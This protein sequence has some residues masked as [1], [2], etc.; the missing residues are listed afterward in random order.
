MGAGS[1][2]NGAK[3]H[4]LWM[5]GRTKR[6]TMRVAWSIDWDS[7]SRGGMWDMLAVSRVLA[8]HKIQSIT[9]ELETVVA[10]GIAKSPSVWCSINA[11]MD[12]P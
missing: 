9:H 7:G 12:A 3:G 6:V 11:S 5:S 2:I 10:C 4:L 8:V 1:S